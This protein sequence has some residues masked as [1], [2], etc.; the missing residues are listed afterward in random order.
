MY[1]AKAKRPALAAAMDAYLRGIFTCGKFK[2][3]FHHIV[4]SKENP[5]MIISMQGWNSAD[6]LHE[7]WD[8]SIMITLSREF[9][10]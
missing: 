10:H 3:V 2:P 1:S 6:E 4:E 5:G 8:V 9:F 7:Y